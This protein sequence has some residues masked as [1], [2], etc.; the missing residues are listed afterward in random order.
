MLN[1]LDRAIRRSVVDE[2]DF[3]IEPGE[4]SAKFRLQDRDVLFLVEQRHDY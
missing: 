3:V 2:N 4:R 1:S